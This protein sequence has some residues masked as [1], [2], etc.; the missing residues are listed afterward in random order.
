MCQNYGGA[1][2]QYGDGGRITLASA[3]HNIIKISVLLL[4]M[5]K[6]FLEILSIKVISEISILECKD[7]FLN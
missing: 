5:Q 3:S 7:D 4:E 6:W 2:S 1:G